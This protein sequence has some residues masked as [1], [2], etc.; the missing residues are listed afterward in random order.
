M[1]DISIMIYVY[2]KSYPWL[3]HK[4]NW[5]H[6]ELASKRENPLP[7]KLSCTQGFHSGLGRGWGA[8]VASCPTCLPAPRLSP[9][10]GGKQRG[11]WAL[12]SLQS[13]LV[14]L[15]LLVYTHGCFGPPPFLGGLEFTSRSPRWH[16]WLRL[17]QP[18]ITLLPQAIA[19]GLQE[20]FY[21]TSF[22]KSILLLLPSPLCP[23]RLRGG[24]WETPR[25]APHRD[26]TSGDAC[27]RVQHRHAGIGHGY[28]LFNMFLCSIVDRVEKT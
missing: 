21:S 17:A 2:K 22:Y 10:S 18:A 15:V 16:W 23:H 7:A 24:V 19:A 14:H 20:S 4:H 26:E 3:N 13:F 28:V 6:C 25:A 9:G 11:C 12:G 27:S 8:G 1:P 5:A